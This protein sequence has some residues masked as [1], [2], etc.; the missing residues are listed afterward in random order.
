LFCYSKHAL[1]QNTITF[2]QKKQ[3]KFLTII[4]FVV[5]FPSS[6]NPTPK[7][8]TIP[9]FFRITCMGAEDT[10]KSLFIEKHTSFTS[11]SSV[12]EGGSHDKIGI[13]TTSE[14]GRFEI[15]FNELTSDVF[16]TWDTTNPQSTDLP[17]VFG[18]TDAVI[19]FFNH[20]DINSRSRIR[21]W[22]HRIT[23]S[24]LGVLGG[25][26]RP[27]PPILLI[28]TRA[29]QMHPHAPLPNVGG[30]GGLKI[31]HIDLLSGDPKFLP[32]KALQY[33][34]PDLLDADHPV[35]LIPVFD[36]DKYLVLAPTETSKDLIKTLVLKEGETYRL[37]RKSLHTGCIRN[38]GELAMAY[39]LSA[40]HIEVH[41]HSSERDRSSPIKPNQARQH[42]TSWPY[43]CSA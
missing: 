19:M 39:A 22:L 28:G 38:K 7:M 16:Q 4:S 26:Q 30:Y 36:E 10:G 6:L 17:E 41:Y 37:G 3:R 29:S 5:L 15:A 42:Q 18:F 1:Q 20:N 40:A 23:S 2:R 27:P 11:P 34:V 21:G 35:S 33:L 8:T 43:P 24:C 9:N 31:A 12:F 13:F 25:E 32:L 14:G